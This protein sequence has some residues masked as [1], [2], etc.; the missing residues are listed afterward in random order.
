LRGEIDESAYIDAL[1][2]DLSMDVA[3][4]GKH[5]LH[6]IFFGG[7]TPSLLSADAVHSILQAVGQL[8][9]FEVDIEITLEANPGTFEQ[10]R[11]RDYRAAGVNRL[12]IGIQSFSDASLQRIGRIH[13]AQQARTAVGMAASAGF[14]NINLDLMFGLP[15]QSLQDATDDVRI[16]CELQPSHISH[17]QLT[18]EPN[19]LFYTQTPVLPAADPLW[20]MQ[21]RCHEVLA[22]DGYAQY[23]ISAFAQPDRQCR[24]N[25]NY[26]RFGDYLGIGAGAHGKITDAGG[27]RITRRWKHRQPAAYIE[28]TRSGNFL[29]GENSLDDADR[30][31]EFVL[32]ALRLSEGFSFTQFEQSTGLGREQLLEAC[33]RVR[34]GLLEISGDGVT[35]T[36]L[37]YRFLNDVLETFLD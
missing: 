5:T 24:H 36:P 10:Q 34:P 11:F 8:L 4:S 9:D 20:E 33:A 17:Y 14:D 3:V 16:A 27:N 12:S 22:N 26:W 13:D 21:I 18:I 25:L 37:G 2:R 28:A 30:Q 7:G 19:T 15:G 35:T 29:A 1:V 32:N 23:E 6:S 31:F